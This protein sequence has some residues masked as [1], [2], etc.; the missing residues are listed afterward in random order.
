LH[1]DNYPINS[2]ILTQ[3]KK[4]NNSKLILV[5]PPSKLN[6]ISQSYSNISQT[7]L[8]SHHLEL[9]NNKLM[10]QAETLNTSASTTIKHNAIV[11]GSLT[12]HL[13]K[14][15]IKGCMNSTSN[16]K[17]LVLKNNILA[18]GTTPQ[19]SK[20]KI[21]TG[22]STAKIIGS[23][24]TQKVSKAGNKMLIVEMTQKQK[25]NDP[26]ATP[27]DVI[28][29]S[30]TNDSNMNVSTTQIKP[31]TAATFDGELSPNL[32][33]WL[34]EIYR[35]IRN[36][37]ARLS[38]LESVLNENVALRKEL[39][40]AQAL[41]YQ[42]QTKVADLPHASIAQQSVSASP[43]SEMMDTSSD[44]AHATR[45]I[46]LSIHASK[47]ATVP[48]ALTFAERAAAVAYKPDPAKIKKKSAST[49]TSEKK[50]IAAA[51]AFMP[52]ASSGPQGFDYVYI[53]RSRKITRS[54]VRRRLRSIGVD[55]NR[56]L[57]IN[58]P[59]TGVIGVLVHTL[60]VLDFS[61]IMT[62]VQAELIEGFDP[63]DPA[64]IADPAYDSY[65]EEARANKAM[66]LHGN[67]CLNALVFLHNTKSHQV[68]SV[69]HAFVDYGWIDP[70]ELRQILNS[71]KVSPN[72]AVAG[73]IFKNTIPGAK[74]KTD[75]DDDMYLDDDVI[76]RDESESLMEEDASG[77]VVSP[78][79]GANTTTVSDES[80]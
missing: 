14:Q 1:Y 51:R 8:E 17:E 56:V 50:R 16:K 62:S 63:L 18:R 27:M 29:E 59:A 75:E 26:G 43:R 79:V 52:A 44:E 70:E 6:K 76:A 69:G 36:Q 46:D 40:E 58:F 20:A 61:K 2:T 65:S 55:T 22:T 45:T 3:N 24:S 78:S 38:Q 53:A 77:D 21:Q 7:S 10:D 54:E 11:S 41:I 4:V 35:V 49:K 68:A 28:Q 67:R 13:Q 72:G 74:N 25:N 31:V 42:L 34:S 47:Y 48:K 60:Y 15:Y 80:P 5:E 64:H 23:P 19:I 39:N 73:G 57:D 30:V 33:E 71:P 12:K 32:P 66:E 9:N 37:D